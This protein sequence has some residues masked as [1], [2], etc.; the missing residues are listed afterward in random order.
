MY[1]PGD[2]MLVLDPIYNSIPRARASAS[3]AASP[4]Q[5]GIEN[6]AL[7][8]T[9]DIVLAGAKST[10]WGFDDAG[11]SPSQTVGPFFSEALRWRDGHVVAF[12]EPQGER[13]V[14]EGRVLDGAARPWATR[15]WRRGS[16][17]RGAPPARRRAMPTRTASGASVP[18][19]TAPSAIETAM[20]GGKAPPCIEVTLLARG[21]LK[22]L[23]TR[24]YL[25]PEAQ[26]RADR[27][28]P[29]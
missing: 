15:W 29:R 26:A 17:R 21:V 27:S 18:P 16:S 20:P 25:C 14:L 3:S 28:S 23:R 8:Y 7:G 11:R 10:R 5:T 13:V 19:P 12:A 6:L 24:V 1:F 9:F 2:P 22:A 4:S